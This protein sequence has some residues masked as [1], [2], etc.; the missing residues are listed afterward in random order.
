MK[1]YFIKYQKDNEIKTFTLK[2]MDLSKE[3][4]PSNIILIKEKKDYFSFFENTK[5]SE[6]EINELFYE[7]SLML[8]SNISLND[9]L[10]I[11]IKNRKSNKAKSFLE[12]LKFSLG[13]NKDINLAIKKFKVS[14]LIAA[15][16]NLSLSSSNISMQIKSLSMILNEQKKIK[17]DFYKAISYPIVL[18][19]TFCLSLISIF[20]F[21]VP[22]FQI[23]FSSTNMPLPNATKLLFF[24]QIVFENYLLAITLI[25]ISIILV[26]MII[27]KES[28]QFVL[29]IDKLLIRKIYIIRDIYLAMH[30]Y[31]FFIVVNILLKSGQEFHNAFYSARILI[32]NK[33]LLDKISN[34]YKIL[35]SGKSISFAFENSNLFD[36]II[37]N[38]INTGE[39]SNNLSK[40]IER[41]VEIYKIRFNE[42]IKLITL[43]I[44][45]MFFL[46]IMVLIIW[47]MLAI[48]VPMW[49]MG[50][51]IKV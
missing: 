49:D 8:D 7:L 26:L 23:M 13:N 40:S 41:I 29:F 30:L 15:F 14:Y 4:L 37:L 2:T 31:I 34:I 47:I 51:L 12:V 21:V 38:L 9:S 35:Q 27:Y 32:K 16:L 28:Q 17:K 42:K 25:F 50:N 11:L 3:D 1:T 5:I 18:M 48:F 6:K 24:V 20:L 45:P 43:L 44:E 33:Y 19:L 39:V 36:D 22:K 46:F 10:D